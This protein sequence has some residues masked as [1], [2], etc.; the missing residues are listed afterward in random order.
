MFI[1]DAGNIHYEGHWKGWALKIIKSKCHIKKQYIGNFMYMSF[2]AH[3]RPLVLW[4]CSGCEP[5]SPSHPVFWLDAMLGKIRSQQYL[6]TWERRWY[7]MCE[8]RS[9]ISWPV[10]RV[11]M[12]TDLGEEMVPDV[13]AEEQ[14]KLTSDKGSLKRQNTASRNAR[15][16]EKKLKIE[17]EENN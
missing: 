17:R 11:A 13:W 8:R 3:Q 12:C 9:R 10:T 16:K 7:Q 15:V 5:P 2:R 14:D 1:F 4:H 6:L